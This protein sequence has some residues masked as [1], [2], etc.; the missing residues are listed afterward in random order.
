MW[1]SNVDEISY[2]YWINTQPS[3]LNEEC[4]EIIEEHSFMWNDVS[5]TREFNFVCQGRPS[6][7][8]IFNNMLCKS[9]VIMYGLGTNKVLKNPIK[10]LRSHK[11]K[12]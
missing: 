5:C 10:P 12:T 1:D 11:T 6:K 2:T 4:L 3:D 8:Y 9:K 7:L